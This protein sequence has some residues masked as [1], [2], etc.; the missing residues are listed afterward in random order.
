MVK[1]SRSQHIC[2]VQSKGKSFCRRIRPFRVLQQ[3]RAGW[4]CGMPPIERY[5]TIRK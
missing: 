5:A 4:E 2:L 1:E 3:V